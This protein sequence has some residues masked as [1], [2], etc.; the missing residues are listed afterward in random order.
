M[1]SSD[2][3]EPIIESSNA[4][5]VQTYIALSVVALVF[6]VGIHDFL[7]EGNL[8]ILGLSMILFAIK[9]GIYF[10]MMSM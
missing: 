9:C 10:G 2:I 5:R 6:S 8:W 3:N 4:N 1:T 7:Q